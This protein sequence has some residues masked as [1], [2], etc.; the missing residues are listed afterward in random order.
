MKHY[1][2]LI[3]FSLAACGT[4]SSEAPTP[5]DTASSVAAITGATVIVGNG[6]APIANANILIDGTELACVGSSAECPVPE[7][8]TVTDASGKYI[9]P[10]LVDAHVHY[11]QS[12]W[13]DG[14]P[15]GLHLRQAYPYP[16][17][18]A[19]LKGNPERFYQSYLCAGITATYD[20][21]GFLWSVEMDEATHDNPDAPFVDAVG[22]LVTHGARSIYEEETGDYKMYLLSDEQTGR[23]RVREL[24]AA[25]SRAIK[26]WFLT[27]SPEEKEELTARMNAVADEARKQ[28]LPMIVHA[29]DL[30][31][32][33]S[34][35]R[36]GAQLLVH[37]VF[38]DS[39]D[40]EFIALMKEHGTVMTPT[41]IVGGYWTKAVIS[42]ME[43][44]NPDID[45]TN[46]CVD[47]WTRGKL[48]TVS[49]LD[50]PDLPPLTDES[51]ARREARTAREVPLMR[52]NVKALYEAGVTLAVGTDAGIR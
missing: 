38:S 1:L 46:G 4:E 42:A 5:A 10:G 9:M 2:G 34:A 39:I 14:R 11:G 45:D 19:E 17:V 44:T 50:D 22:P 37:N 29:T 31:S 48:A 23:E 16:D 12:A 15:D 32:A 24:A 28:G 13:I 18:Y 7:G 40:E 8:A 20:V 25:G 35:V 49:E 27:P 52:A 51:R 30:E 36:A 41:S 47:P 33:K 21:G 6:S 43:R 26:V 3:A